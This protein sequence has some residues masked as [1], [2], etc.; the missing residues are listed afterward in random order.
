[1]GIR[2]TPLKMKQLI[3]SYQVFLSNISKKR[4]HVYVR[5]VETSIVQTAGYVIIGILIQLALVK[6]VQV[7][8]RK[9]RNFKYAFWT[10][11][12]GVELSLISIVGFEIYF[13]FN[14]CY[15]QFYCG[16]GQG[17][18]LL[19]CLITSALL[20]LLS[21][22]FYLFEYYRTPT[23][24]QVGSTPDYIGKIR[25]GLLTM[26][27]ILGFIAVT[28]NSWM[29]LTFEDDD[30][31]VFADLSLNEISV[32]DDLE[33]TSFDY[34]EFCGDGGKEKD[35]TDFLALDYAYPS[36]PVQF[37][38][39]NEKYCSLGT[40]GLLTTTVLWLAIIS[41]A[42]TIIT[43]LRADYE[44]RIPAMTRFAFSWGTGALMLIGTLVWVITNPYDIGFPPDNVGGS[45]WLVLLAGLL[46]LSGEIVNTFFAKQDE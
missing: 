9:K 45:F 26:S 22:I 1:M 18:A 14:P 38:N 25:L 8:T 30:G 3:I 32:D 20:I 36:A 44:N 5:S 2:I 10:F 12:A 40:V 37:E 33:I 13:H 19:V 42:V 16:F 46:A 29:S 4:E 6:T 43:H 35:M 31:N 39:D 7:Y 27:L 17:I 15:G 41:G 34:D 23:E 24:P 28:G 21:L 11:F